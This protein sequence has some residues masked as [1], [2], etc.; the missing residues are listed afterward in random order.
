MHNIKFHKT[1]QM[2]NLDL[3]HNIKSEIHI[4][5]QTKCKFKEENKHNALLI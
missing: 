4:G 1:L 2:F 5:I 3:V